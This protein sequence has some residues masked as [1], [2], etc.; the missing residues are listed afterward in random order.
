MSDINKVLRNPPM[1]DECKVNGQSVAKA[2][3]PNYLR[4]LDPD[5]V[6]G[7]GGPAVADRTIKI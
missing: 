6:W 3:V 4:M 2:Y 5:V 1:D 7:V